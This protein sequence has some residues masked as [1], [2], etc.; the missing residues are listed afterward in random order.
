MLLL[1]CCCRAVSRWWFVLV[2][3]LGSTRQ[4]EEEKSLLSVVAC[5]LS[6]AHAPTHTRYSLLVLRYSLLALDLSFSRELVLKILLVSYRSFFRLFFRLFVGFHSLS[7]L[8]EMMVMVRTRPL[9]LR[10]RHLVLRPT[11]VLPLPPLA[12]VA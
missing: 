1:R 5:S 9:S 6:L 4:E 3:V 2:F 10:R 8:V 11:A 12:R 7:W